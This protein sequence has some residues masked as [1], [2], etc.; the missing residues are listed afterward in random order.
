MIIAIAGPYSAST[1]KQRQKNLE[2][3]NSIAARILEMG[4]IP[5][6]G[7]NAA[8]PVVNLAKVNDPYKAIMEISMA[9]I[10][11]CDAL[12]FLSESPGANR[13]RDAFLSRGLPVYY[14]L[15]EIPNDKSS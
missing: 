4:H 11:N 6:I 15:E 13:E 12:F 9:V 14:R 3:L 10:H 1:R 2:H 7:V 8:L 5:V